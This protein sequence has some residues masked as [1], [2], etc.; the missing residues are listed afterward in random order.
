MRC[1]FC[2]DKEV[3]DFFHIMDTVT[4]PNGCSLN[5]NDEPV[6]TIYTCVAD[7]EKGIYY[8]TSYDNR[9]VRKISFFDS[10]EEQIAD[11]W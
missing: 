10:R 6:K 11:F 7:L 8:L 3:E 1:I 4:V 2:K 5:E 9:K